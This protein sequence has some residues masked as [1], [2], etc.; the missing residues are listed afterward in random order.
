MNHA[1]ALAL[2]AVVSHEQATELTANLVTLLNTQV[3]QG[4]QVRLDAS[5]VEQFDSSVLAVLLA[6]RRATLAHGGEL[7]VEGLPEQAHIL[8]E[9]YGINGLFV[10]A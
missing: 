8:A 10:K 5:M 4:Q 6:C 2:P 3:S 9:L 7:L 1:F